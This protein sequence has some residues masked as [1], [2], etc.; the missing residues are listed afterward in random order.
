MVVA[1]LFN[2]GMLPMLIDDP[3]VGGGIGADVSLA[4]SILRAY[5]IS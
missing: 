4:D 5:A 3:Q 2:G 1:P